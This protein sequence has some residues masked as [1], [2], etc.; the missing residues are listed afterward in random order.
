MEKV[1][2][3]E[4]L[5]KARHIEEICLYFPN[6]EQEINYALVELMRD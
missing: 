2:N 3:R 1:Q 6:F 4:C 5:K